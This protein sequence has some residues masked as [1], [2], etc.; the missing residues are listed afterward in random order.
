MASKAMRRLC[1]HRI[2]RSTL[3]L[4]TTDDLREIGVAAR[5]AIA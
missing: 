3:P 5:W 4:L 1:E 2:D